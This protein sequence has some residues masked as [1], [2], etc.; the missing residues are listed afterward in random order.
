MG[1]SSYSFAIKKLG[2]DV[3]TALFR[4]LKQLESASSVD[5]LV[6]NHIGRCH[7]LTGD[8]LG[9]YAMDLGQPHRLIFTLEIKN[10]AVIIEVKDYH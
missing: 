5:D 7:A 1:K 8:R 6:K 10:T 9:Q 4:R 3:A 2:A